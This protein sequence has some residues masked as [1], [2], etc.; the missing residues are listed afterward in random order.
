MKIL[1]SV[2]ASVDIQA[3]LVGIY[4]FLPFGISAPAVT[5]SET[6]R[7]ERSNKSIENLNRQSSIII[8]FNRQSTLQLHHVGCALLE[9]IRFFQFLLANEGAEPISQLPVFVECN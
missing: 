9:F 5:R 7:L 1:I 3:L 2:R 6:M 4:I 8:H